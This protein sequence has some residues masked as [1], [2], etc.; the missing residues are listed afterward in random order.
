LS[1]SNFYLDFAALMLPG[2]V[3]CNSPSLPLLI[4][5]IWTVPLSAENISFSSGLSTGS[6]FRGGLGRKITNVITVFLTEID[7]GITCKL[8][9]TV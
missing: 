5:V 9:Y 1:T 4:L 8:F 2:L 7:F 6:Q 3:N